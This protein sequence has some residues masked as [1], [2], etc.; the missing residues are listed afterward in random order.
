MTA[1][2]PTVKRELLSCARCGWR[3]CSQILDPPTRK[4][5]P[6]MSNKCRTITPTMVDWRTFSLQ[7]VVRR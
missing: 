4:A 7:A 3:C 5:V 1:S 2:Y 6:G